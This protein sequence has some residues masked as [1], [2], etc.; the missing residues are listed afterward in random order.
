MLRKK[1]WSWLLL[2]LK[3]Q[4]WIILAQ[5]ILSHLFLKFWRI[6]ALGFLKQGKTL[7][8][9]ILFYREPEVLSLFATI[10]RKLQGN[11]AHLIPKILENVLAVSLNQL[12]DDSN[13]TKNNM[14]NLFKLVQA[15]IENCFQGKFSFNFNFILKKPYLIFL[16]RYSKRLLTWLFGE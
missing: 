9:P 10:I 1:S 4:I 8:K 11:V 3:N 14:I 6:I 16:P 12:E 7:Y 2:L 5:I 13:N 15:I